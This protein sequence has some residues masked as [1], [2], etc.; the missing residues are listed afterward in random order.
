MPLQQYVRQVKP[1]NKSYTPPVEKIQSLY[2]KEM[3]PAELVKAGGRKTK[4]L[5]KAIEDGTP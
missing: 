1:R 5:Q 4:T 3:T 2:E